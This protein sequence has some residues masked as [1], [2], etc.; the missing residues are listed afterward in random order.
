VLP[1]GLANLC[2]TRGIEV[3]AAMPAVDLDDGTEAAEPATA[4][5]LRRA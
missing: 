3:I 4:S 1:D 2:H 5:V